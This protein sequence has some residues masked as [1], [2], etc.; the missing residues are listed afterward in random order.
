VFFSVRSTVRRPLRKLG[1]AFILALSAF[2]STGTSAKTP[3]TESGTAPLASV[4][5]DQLPKDAH[6]TLALIHQGGPFPHSKDGVVF[7]NRER[8]LPAHP[9]GYYREY[10]VRTPGARNRGA[11][12]IV[13]GGRQPTVPDACFYTP[14]HYASFSRIVQ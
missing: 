10:T 11:R 4:Q 8:L 5:I 1:L 6:A 12:R 7:R 13:C 2:G 9:G 3:S 14:D